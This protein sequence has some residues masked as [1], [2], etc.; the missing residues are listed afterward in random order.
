MSQPVK[1]CM[2]VK[3]MQMR[4]PFPQ[5]MTNDI[6]KV[7]FVAHTRVE[8]NCQ[9]YILKFTYNIVQVVLLHLLLVVLL[10]TITLLAIGSDIQ[11]FRQCSLIIVHVSA[12]S[13][14]F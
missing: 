13:W 9:M 8:H 12:S 11:I 5:F 10:V 2:A 3:T 14:I 6:Q 1:Q 4:P 7:P